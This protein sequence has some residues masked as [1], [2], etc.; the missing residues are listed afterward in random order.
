MKSK[1]NLFLIKPKLDKYDSPAKLN[2]DIKFVSFLE[3]NTS[4]NLQFTSSILATS[5]CSIL[6]LLSQS[7]NTNSE[8]DSPLVTKS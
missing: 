5:A 7:Q 4:S 8:F 6:A 3:N 2:A 1:K